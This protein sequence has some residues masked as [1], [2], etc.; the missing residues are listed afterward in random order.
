MNYK[1]LASVLSLTGGEFE[2]FLLELKYK[3]FLSRETYEK[4]VKKKMNDKDSAE[5][6][7]EFLKSF[8]PQVIAK[9]FV[10]GGLERTDLYNC[11]KMLPWLKNSG[12]YN[13]MRRNLMKAKIEFK[14]CDIIEFLLRHPE[15]KFDYIDFSNIL[16]YVYQEDDSPNYEK[17]LE[18]LDNIKRIF[19]RNLK[20]GG[21]FAIDYMFGINKQDLLASDLKLDPKQQLLRDLYFKIYDQLSK[22]FPLETIE[23]AKAGQATVLTGSKDMVLVAK[24]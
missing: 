14:I 11:K 23:I 16:L 9:S 4:I 10:K 20:D 12:N 22:E 8:P 6:W 2:K 15:C 13:A 5:F 17:V 18:A 1:R 7:S 21:T 19:E 3:G 24:K